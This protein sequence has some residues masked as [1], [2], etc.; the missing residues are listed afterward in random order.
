MSRFWRVVFAWILV[1]ALPLQGYAA[2]AKLFC[3]PAHHGV[4]ASAAA[5][6]IDHAGHSAHAGTDLATT[7]TSK[8]AGAGKCS[9]CASCCS[10]VA[11]AGALVQTPVIAPQSPA[12]ATVLQ[13]GDCALIEGLE[14]P[15]RPTFA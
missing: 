1:L 13:A 7:E 11:I 6:N 12:V 14:R 4:A 8:T 9:A 10:A 15:P 3:G 5:A 2:Q